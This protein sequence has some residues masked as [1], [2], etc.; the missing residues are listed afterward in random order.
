VSPSSAAGKGRQPIFRRQRNTLFR[1]E[2]PVRGIAGRTHYRLRTDSGA[3]DG[4]IDEEQ[5]EQV[6]HRYDDDGFNRNYWQP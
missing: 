4:D 5:A 1:L 3:T 6:A 2:E